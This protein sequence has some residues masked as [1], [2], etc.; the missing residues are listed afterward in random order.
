MGATP[1]Q[2]KERIDR[3]REELSEDVTS[4]ADRVVPGRVIERKK[5]AARHRV[6]DLRD[7]IMGS[8]S[9]VKDQATGTLGAAAGTVSG[10]AESLGST[11]HDM[12]ERAVQRTQ[13]SPLAAG[14]IAF[15]AGM[16]IARLMPET[17][18]EAQAG[19]ALREHASDM[20]QPLTEAAK[21]A[22]QEVKGAVVPAAREAAST[23]KD[24]ATEAV[25]QTAQEAKQAAAE[26][27]PTSS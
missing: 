20:A 9:V 5:Q 3:T 7:R 1:D 22:A 2:L 6:V 27:T 12:P 26:V 15:G 10:T 23:L 16:V 13:G 4:L 8:A 25:Q 24:T 21:E 14:L 18:A 17:Q 11:V 19:Q